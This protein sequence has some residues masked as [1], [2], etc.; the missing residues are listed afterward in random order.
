MALT[1]N[2]VTRLALSSVLEEGHNDLV[3]LDDG[4]T[5]SAMEGALYLQGDKVYDLGQIVNFFFDNADEDM[6]EGLVVQTLDQD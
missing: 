6:K 5:Y 1:F 3:F 2:R 4:D